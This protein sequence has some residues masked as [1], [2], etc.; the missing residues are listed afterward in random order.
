[1]ALALSCTGTA[2]LSMIYGMKKHG[3]SLKMLLWTVIPKA[4]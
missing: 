3:K 1:M 4:E 2:S